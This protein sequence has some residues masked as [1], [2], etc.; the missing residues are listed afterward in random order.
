MEY[1]RSFSTPGSH[2]ISA[3]ISEDALPG[4]ETR[5]LAIDVLSAIPVLIVDG[6][7]SAAAP[8]RSSDY[9]RYAIAPAD[10]SQPAFVTRTIGLS[11]FVSQSLHQSVTPDPSSTPRILILQN[12]GAMTE[13]QH[14]TVE[15]FVKDGGG[16]FMTVGPRADANSC[17][18]LGFRDGIGWLPA[19]L[20]APAG[21]EPPMNS[22]FPVLS[23]LEKT[24]V[25]LLNESTPESFVRSSFQRWWKLDTQTTGSGNVVA[26]LTNGDQLLIEKAVGKGRVLLAAVPL[27][28]TWPTS[29]L[30]S[31]DFVRLCHECLYHLAAARAAD[32][33]LEPMQPI[34]YRPMPG[35]SAGGITIKLP[36]GEQRRSDVKAWPFVFEETRDPGVYRLTTDSG[37][38]QYYVVKPDEGEANLAPCS[39][40]DRQAVAALYPSERLRYENER[41]PILAALRDSEQDLDLG[42]IFFLLV[43]CLLAAEVAYERSLLR[44]NPHYSGEHVSH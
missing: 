20:D 37:R 2:L 25:D 39:D 33:N 23:S 1:R 12:V 36:N 27:D 19:R 38:V 41:A 13:V 10:L 14:R 34:V 16:V 18:A 6:D 15:E 26:R 22:V 9:I 40:E 7:I 24:F 21:G 4:Q 29:L 3:D 11:E 42:W 44:Q 35:E 8:M 30:R 31:H 43:L 5:N 32:V 28:D 17:N